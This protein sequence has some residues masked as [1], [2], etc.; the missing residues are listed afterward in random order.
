MIEE[1]IECS[2]TPYFCFKDVDENKPAGSIKIRIETIGYFLKRYR[3]KL[4]RKN[5]QRREIEE[6]LAAF[7]VSLREQRSASVALGPAVGV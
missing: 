6:K 7:E 4:V 1:I 2:G 3:E 5:R